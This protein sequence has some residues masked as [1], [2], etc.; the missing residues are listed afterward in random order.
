MEANKEAIAT[1]LTEL[2]EEH[3]AED[4]YFANLDKVNRAT[5][6]KRLKEIG[7]IKLMPKK[8]TLS[9]A[10][11]PEMP[12]GEQAVLEQYLQLLDK[13]GELS[14]KIKDTITSLDV[15]VI[16]R[17]KTL[18]EAEVK[19]LVV[20]D[21]WMATIERSVQTEM[22]RISQRLTQRIKELAERYETPLPLQ[23][24]E[25]QLLEDKV[26]KHLEAMGFKI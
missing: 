1:Q 8:Q 5:V 11:E 22:E 23:T 17:Y 19:Q 6:Q 21:K 3:N 4:G 2:E 13:Q 12:Y 25:L 14:K 10:A 15:K 26:T 9:I 24:K 18:T 7:T 20:D 16:E